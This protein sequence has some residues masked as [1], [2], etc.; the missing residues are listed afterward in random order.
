MVAKLVL[1]QL[2]KT[3]G[4][5]TPLTLP[6]VN[7]TTGQYMQNDGSGGLSWVAAPTDT[8]GLSYASQWRLHT[9]LSAS[10]AAP[11]TNIA[12]NWEQPAVIDF[13][14]IIGSGTPM[15]VNTSTGAWT[16][17]ATGVWYV[18]LT[19]DSSAISSAHL[20]GRYIYTTDDSGSA[21]QQAVYINYTHAQSAVISDRVEWLMKVADKTTDFVRFSAGTSAHTD[22]IYGD[23]DANRT[24]AT[25][26]KLGDA[27]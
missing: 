22:D 3:G 11:G 1:D 14:G 5:L 4:L 15:V 8:Q 13:P 9:T 17:P 2:E 25:F 10:G 21:W 23:T 19:T 16:F 7:A 12:A 6:S 20:S 18:A 27:S 24:Y 26:I